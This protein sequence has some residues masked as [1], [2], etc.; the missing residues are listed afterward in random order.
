MRKIGGELKKR[1]SAQLGTA[2]RNAEP[3]V[4]LRISRDVLP[5]SREAL[6]EQRSVLSRGGAFSDCGAACAHPRTDSEDGDIFVCAS[7]GGVLR[8]FRAEN[9][10][11]LG[12]LSFTELSVPDGMRDACAC[13]LAF[14]EDIYRNA[15]G[16]REAVTVGG[17]YLFRVT[18]DGKLYVRVLDGE[19]TETLLASGVSR[20]SAVCG[21]R[22]PV[23]AYG[24]GLF[25][26]WL[27]DGGGLFYRELRGD[28]WG[29]AVSVPSVPAGTVYSDLAAF[30]TWD[31]R[32]GIQ[33]LCS[34]GTVRKLLSGSDLLLRCPEEHL[35][36]SRLLLS[37]N[38]CETEVR[39]GNERICLGVSGISCA[40]RSC[41]AG[42]PRIS[43]VYNAS[44]GIGAEL[45]Y[46]GE[47]FPPVPGSEEEGD[48][49]A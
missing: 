10:E 6:L 31:Y 9:G 11:D 45:F 5:L 13:A 27:S 36:V 8:L 47:V 28:A 23:R 12:K 19:D 16:Q 30:R 17:P 20:V 25:V 43:A 35:A 42:P 1:L 4:S 41:P 18:S 46:P 39:H 44:D 14:E 34:D 38:V 48:N 32:V 49:E 37:G 29:D 40:Y 21:V 22:T 15:D 2:E 24:R 7:D 26:F 3:S 33:L